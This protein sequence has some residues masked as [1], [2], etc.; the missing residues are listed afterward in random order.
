M[1]DKIRNLTKKNAFIIALIL[2]AVVKQLLVVGLPIYA[3]PAAA[4]DDQLMKNWA[5][6]MA[7]GDWTGTFNAYT[8]M[9]E[10]GFSLFLAI[11]YRLHLPFIFTI[12]LGYSVACG[13]FSTA[14]NK[15]FSSKIFVYIVYI[16]LLF[17]PLS[18]SLYTLQRV[19][20]NGLG[21][22]L[23]LLIFGGIV[24]MYFSVLEEKQW[25]LAVWSC[26]TGLSLGYLWI[27]KSDTIWVMPFV[28]VVTIVMLG[29]LIKNRRNVKSIPR[30]LFLC[31]PFLGIFLFTHFVEFC[32]VQRY[33]YAS[34]EYY[35]PAL[36]DMTHVKT[37]NPIDKVGLSRETL[38]KLYKVSP[39]LASVE[40]E[41]EKAMDKNTRYDTHPEDEEVEDG[42]IGWT[43]LEAFN[44]ADVYES[45]ETANKFY[46][47]IYDELETAF[48]DGTLEK[49]ET[50]TVQNYYLDTQEHRSQLMHRIADTIWYM[51]TFTETKA[52]VKADS[53]GGVGARDFEQLTREKAVYAEL[54]SD[55]IITGWIVFPDYRL[56]DIKIYVEDSKGNQF[57]EV[58]FEKSLDVYENLKEK[59]NKNEVANSAKC[60]F[61]IKWNVGDNESEN[62]TYYLA[63]YQNDTCVGKIEIQESGFVPVDGFKYTGVLDTYTSKRIG[64]NQM[65]R[66]ENAVN[67][68]NTIGN[69]YSTVGKNIFYVSIVAYVLLTAGMVIDLTRKKYAKVNAWLLVT[70]FSMSIIVFS[71]GIAVIDLT[72]CP[73]V[74]AMY[75]SAGYALMLA[76]E[77]IAI[78]KCIEMFIKWKKE[79]GNV[80][81]KEK[82][83]EL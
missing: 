61:K 73:A 74:N 46:K 20:R 78:L 63:V 15:I 19:Y 80:L 13:I 48:S 21:M 65:K 60:R 41:L 70:G 1:K 7:V 36:Y 22:I 42:W 24:H 58:E 62:E 66:A 14:L 71:A 82:Q 10:P 37:E 34:V 43:L 54:E 53:D 76:A 55:Y 39:T 35:G 52:E 16:V 69:S 49:I 51:A 29:I 30:Y 81:V 9:K 56:Q 26:I 3:I 79:R 2:A 11:C 32:N 23:T 64:E 25:K 8:F 33:G 18:Y 57:K 50:S 28:V 45:C 83:N 4:C 75:L 77:F 59:G 38:K 5:Y 68:V 67:R 72:Q 6:S 27:T 40:D 44:K 12:T 31:I 47:N 17:N